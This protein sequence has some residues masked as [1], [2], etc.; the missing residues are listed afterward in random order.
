M[1]FFNAAGGLGSVN[2][3]NAA[4]PKAGWQNDLMA[5]AQDERQASNWDNG[6]YT[7][8][9]N[10]LGQPQD[11]NMD[12]YYQALKNKAATG[13]KVNMGSWGNPEMGPAGET[14]STTALNDLLDP[15]RPGAAARAQRE[16]GK[17]G[18]QFTQ[19]G[20]HNTGILGNG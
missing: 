13:A 8:A 14:P 4:L 11:P 18:G 10:P 9:G 19:A 20:Q 1:A 17:R 15:T 5:Q 2:A 3:L 6:T 7:G 16:A 12:A